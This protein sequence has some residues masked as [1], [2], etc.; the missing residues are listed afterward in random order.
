M[1]GLSFTPT[2]TLNISTDSSRAIHFSARPSLNLDR[3][4][5]SGFTITTT[6]HKNDI[7]FCKSPRIDAYLISLDKAGVRSTPLADRPASSTGR[8]PSSIVNASP[9]CRGCLSCH[10]VSPC[11]PTASVCVA[12]SAYRRTPQSVSSVSVKATQ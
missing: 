11:I 7:P 3:Q 1:R 4:L 12:R 5:A 8:N 6:Q 10:Y 9:K 2:L